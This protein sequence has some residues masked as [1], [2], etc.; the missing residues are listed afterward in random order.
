MII[1]LKHTISKL[2]KLF[3]SN[4]S[5]VL[6]NSIFSFVSL[7]FLAKLLGKK[8]IA[9]LNFCD[10]AIGISI[11]SIAAQWSTDIVNPWYYYAIALTV[12]SVISLLITV[13]ERKTLFLKS[14]LQGKPVIII[15]EG[16][17]DYRS[18]KRSKLD[19]ADIFG[20]CRSKGY[21]DINEISYAIFETN[22]EI[23]ILPKSANRP[24]VLRDLGLNEEPPTLTKYIVL[25]GKLDKNYL[26][27]I[28]KDEKWAYKK[29]KVKSKR[30]LN[31]I[32]VAFHDEKTDELTIHYK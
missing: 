19:M 1:F 4:A 12:F 18:F 28:K 8:Q 20:L 7:F 9:E 15:R 5:L 22:G 3:M 23:S 27:Q 21:F 25:D 29:L 31:K 10:Y 14:F 26:E 2:G 13:F 6:L 24:T 32:L 11:G 16:K 17:I 30:Q